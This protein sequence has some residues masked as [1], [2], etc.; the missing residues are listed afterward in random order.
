MGPGTDSDGPLA[1]IRVVDF[2]RVVAGPYCTMLLGDGGADVVKVERPG[3]GDDTRTWGPPFVDGESTYFLGVNRNKRSI[4]L[5]LGHVEGRGLAGSLIDGADVVVESFRPGT[6]DRWGLGWEAVR[7]RNPSV[8]YCSISA[9]GPSGPYRDHAGYDVMVSAL[10]GLMGITG[11]PGGPP[12]KIGVAVVDVATGLYAHGAIVSAL[13]HRERTGMGQLVETSL[14]AADL[15]ILI[16]AASGYL[17]AGHVLTPMGTAHTSIV[18]YQAFACSDGHVLIGAGNDK[19]FGALARTLGLPDLADDARFAT[20]A[21]RV[22]HREALVPLIEAITRTRPVA[23]WVEALE[24]AGVAVAPINS[25]DRVF[26]D[27]QVRA[28]DR[29]T[30]IE[31]PRLGDLRMVAPAVTMHGSPLVI[32]RP[33]PGLGEHTDEVLTGVLGLTPD[34]VARLRSDGV[35]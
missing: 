35:I 34:E 5:D 15:A 2:T 13:L 20:N 4:T 24:T 25:I 22:E 3:A 23:A 33:P 8:V 14:L 30:S 11:V 31:H 12:V 17:A 10:G 28:T 6:M 18:P 16:N 9:F 26:A 29:V 1:G 21:D 19:L 27:P 7:A 32:R